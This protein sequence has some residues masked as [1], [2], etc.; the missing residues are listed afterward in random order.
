MMSA[1]HGMAPARSRAQKECRPVAHPVRKGGEVTPCHVDP[2]TRPGVC[3]HDRGGGGKLPVQV[4]NELGERVGHRG[5]VGDASVEHVCDIP[6]RVPFAVVPGAQGE[7]G[8]VEGHDVGML[9]VVRAC[10][11]E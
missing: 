1:A 3:V 8:T 7:G 9:R 4:G 6:R 11:R 5:E 10:Q 2:R